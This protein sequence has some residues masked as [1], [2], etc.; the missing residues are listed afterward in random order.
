MYLEADRPGVDAYY[1][2]LA[3]EGVGS[4][5][6][7][8]LHPLLP[9]SIWMRRDPADRLAILRRLIGQPVRIV[10]YTH[11]AIAVT[12]YGPDAFPIYSQGRV[13]DVKVDK[14]SGEYIVWLERGEGFPAGGYFFADIYSVVAEPDRPPIPISASGE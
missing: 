1:R 3:D 6:A 7:P 2:K 8:I 11:Y 10:G 9:P 4:H 5:R 14:W 13:R 12:L